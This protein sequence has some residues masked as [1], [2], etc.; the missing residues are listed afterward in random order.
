MSSE[1]SDEQTGKG[2]AGEAG[3]SRTRRGRG[4]RSRSSGSR[5]GRAESKESARAYLPS[6]AELAREEAEIA[7]DEGIEGLHVQSLKDKPLPELLEFAEAM[8]V[9]NHSGLRKQDLIFAILNAQTARQ[10]KVFARGVLEILQDGFGFLRSQ[11]QSYL[12]GPRQ[13]ALV[14]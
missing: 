7:D 14:L 13:V 4:R 8:E 11:D 3:G 9:E 12:A 1:R 2:K 5:P 6:D 10:G